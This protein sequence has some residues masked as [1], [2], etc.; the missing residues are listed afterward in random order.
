MEGI[1]QAPTPVGFGL[2]TVNWRAVDR[3]VIEITRPRFMYCLPIALEDQPE[4][5]VLV[6]REVLELAV[7]ELD[8]IPL[9]DAM[10]YWYRYAVWER[11]EH[12]HR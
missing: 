2:L 1:R 8:A 9:G 6:P 10:P 4:K 3:E 5:L 12:S 11:D 7:A